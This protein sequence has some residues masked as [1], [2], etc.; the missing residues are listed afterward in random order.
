MAETHWRGKGPM[1]KKRQGGDHGGRERRRHLG[2]GSH[3]QS[4][5][6]LAL[7][8]AEPCMKENGRIC[9]NIYIPRGCTRTA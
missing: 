3:W 5:D 6:I 7:E 8:D 2:I 4:E 1:H 9:A